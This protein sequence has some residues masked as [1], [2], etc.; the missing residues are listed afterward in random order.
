MN[1]KI[2]KAIEVPPIKTGRY[3]KY[4]FHEM[5]IGDSFFAIDIPAENL[6]SA[7]SYFG[8]RNKRKYMVRKV[9]GGVRCWRME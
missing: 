2:E 4:P 6:R 8:L 3:T 5:N 9:D 7:A 1:Y